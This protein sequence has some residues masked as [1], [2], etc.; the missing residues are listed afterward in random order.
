M[1]DNPDNTSTLRAKMMKTPPA[2]SPD[3]R[4]CKADRVAQAT[5]IMMRRLAGEA[6]PDLAADFGLSERTID[7]R[8]AEAREDTSIIK[9][10]QGVFTRELLPKSLVVLLNA[11]DSPDEQ[12]AVKVAMKVFDNLKLLTNNLED[13]PSAHEEETLDVFR[14]KLTRRPARKTADAA[15]SISTDAVVIDV[16]A[17]DAPPVEASHSTEPPAAGPSAPPSVPLSAAD[18]PAEPAS[19]APT[20]DSPGGG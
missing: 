3:Q 13:I 16:S 19:P 18:T 6:T 5:E 4:L 8:L 11:L 14:A 20:Q 2:A 7:R 17:V 15:D 1:R 12:L 10:V 9:H